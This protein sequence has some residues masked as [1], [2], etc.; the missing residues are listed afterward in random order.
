MKRFAVAYTNFFD[1]HLTQEIVMAETEQ[2]ARWMHTQTGP[3]S[4]WKNDR[5]KF[6]GDTDAMDA[7][8]FQ[9]WCFDSDFLVSVV[10]VLGP[11]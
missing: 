1:N 8:E 3:N 4:G 6:R 5:E 7:D 11:F 9:E 2:D 10:E